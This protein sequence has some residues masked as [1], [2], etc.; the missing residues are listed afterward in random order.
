MRSETKKAQSCKRDGGI[1][2]LE[3]IIERTRTLYL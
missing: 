3:T 2:D 1:L